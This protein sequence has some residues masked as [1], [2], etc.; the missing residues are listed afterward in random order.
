[1]I[2][3]AAAPTG[4]SISARD[5]AA[6]FTEPIASG[7]PFSFPAAASSVSFPASGFAKPTGSGS[8]SGEPSFSFPAF[9]SSGAESIFAKPTGLNGDKPSFSFSLQPKS[10]SGFAVPTGF[11]KDFKEKF[12]HHHAGTDSVGAFAA[13][14]GS[15]GGFPSGSFSGLPS[16]TFSLPEPT[17]T[18]SV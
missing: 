17:A 9:G 7:S 6:S 8:G 13:P 18:A 15:F 2:S 10:G 3:G 11:G 5:A 16:G 14:T 4:L 12:H 1:M